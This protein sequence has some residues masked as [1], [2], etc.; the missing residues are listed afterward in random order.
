MADRAN[1]SRYTPATSSLT[2]FSSCFAW[3]VASG[4]K[5]R[6]T[7]FSF[8]NMIPATTWIGGNLQRSVLHEDLFTSSLP[9]A[10]TLLVFVYART[11]YADQLPPSW[12]RAFIY[13]LPGYPHRNLGPSTV[14][15]VENMLLSDTHVAVV[16]IS[17]YSEQ[18]IDDVFT[19]NL[20]VAA[21]VGWCIPC[22][23]ARLLPR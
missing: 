13:V 2:F 19:D 15:S 16:L 7:M 21:V 17:K 11:I 10:A 9:P 23:M 18:I 8:S 14:Q 4:T 1:K 5:T 22:R 20:L 3:R 12:W 6:S